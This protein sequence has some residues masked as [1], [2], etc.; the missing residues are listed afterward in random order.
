MVNLVNTYICK[1]SVTTDT[2]MPLHKLCCETETILMAILFPLGV[3]FTE[4]GHALMLITRTVSVPRRG[5]LTDS[6][7]YHTSIL[8]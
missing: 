7:K 2:Q 6:Q 8:G 1:G 5:A 3:G 4:H